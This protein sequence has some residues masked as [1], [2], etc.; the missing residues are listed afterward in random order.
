[1]TRVVKIMN[2]NRVTAEFNGTKCYFRSTFEYH[3]ACYL[4]FLQKSKQIKAWFYEPQLFIFHGEITAP[5]QYRPDFKIVNKD[6]SEYYQELK[7]YRD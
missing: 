4:Q 6:G 3:W 1:M 5:I 7:G 2:N